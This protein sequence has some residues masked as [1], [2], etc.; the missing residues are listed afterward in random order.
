LMDCS[1]L[2][3]TAYKDATNI[4]NLPDDPAR[5][6]NYG[7]KVSSLRPGDIVFYKEGGGRISH[8]GVYAGNN[9]VIHASDYFGRVV[10]SGMR[11]PGDGYIGARRL[12]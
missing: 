5:Q 8:A 1:C 3:L 11:W 9:E 7:R 4:D 6:W 12:V 2:I 10:K